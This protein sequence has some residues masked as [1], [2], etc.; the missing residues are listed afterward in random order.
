MKTWLGVLVSVAWTAGQCALGNNHIPDLKTLPP[1]HQVV[2]VTY[3][4]GGYTVVLRDG[5]T[6]EFPEFSLRMKTDHGPM[7]PE[8]G[9][10]A[11]IPASMVGDRAFLIFHKPHEISS[12]IKESCLSCIALG[13]KRFINQL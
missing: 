11:L 4:N 9:S 3:C 10:A 13:E 2:S 8:P 6:R 7:G 12:F 5:S 1:E